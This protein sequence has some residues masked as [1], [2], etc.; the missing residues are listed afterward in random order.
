MEI[1]RKFG[2]FLIL[3][4]FLVISTLM[5]SDYKAWESQLFSIAKPVEFLVCKKY[6]T[7]HS[8]CIIQTLGT[9]GI[10]L[11]FFAFYGC[12]YSI[13]TL[14]FTS[15]I[16]IILSTLSLSSSE[17]KNFNVEIIN[18]LKIFGIAGGLLEVY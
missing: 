18:I 10:I 8:R 5:L 17:Q 4:Y 1:L 16:W 3:M 7:E 12:K 9:I 11:T 15:L 6:L 2:F 14:A 13:K